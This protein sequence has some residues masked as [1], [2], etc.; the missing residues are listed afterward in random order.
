MIHVCYGLHDRDGRYSKFTGTSMLSI[1]ENTSAPSHSITVHILHDSTLSQSNH[2]KFVEI[3]EKYKQNVEFF[4]VEIFCMDKIQFVL[5]KLKQY[6]QSRFS[7]G[8]FY[9][10]M[11]NQKSFHEKISKMI[12]LDSDTIV[13]LDIQEL[14]DYPM[15]EYAVASV[16]ELWATRSYMVRNK[17]LL[18]S[19]K[20][21]VEDYFCSGVLV[22]NFDKLE[23]DFFYKG[24]NWLAENLQCECPDQDIL[25]YFFST[26]YCKLPEKF[27]LFVGIAKQQDKNIVYKNIY[28]YSGLS[29]GLDMKNAHDKLFFDCFMKT[30]WFDIDF[31][32]HIS[33]IMKQIYNEQK[34]FAV[35]I[36]AAIS[37]KKRAFF[38]MPNDIETV[39]KI[40]QISDEEEI[41]VATSNESIDNLIESMKNSGGKK[42]YFIVISTPGFDSLLTNAGFK[43]GKDFI[44]AMVMLPN[45]YGLQ[46]PTQAI[47]KFL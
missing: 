14:W 5:Q 36:S 30:S 3:A 26:N 7:I 38:V 11:V 35:Q 32:E 29:L 34:N 27:D 46:M 4:N 13:N 42:I 40:F 25:N 16:P 9:R 47:I 10:L 17:Y 45:N 33:Q 20:V 37:G 24:V 39:K 12:Y 31:I 2:D 18:N 41:I 43:A 23:E 8:A 1:F 19:G 28:H 44:N 15:E 6:V 21:K 22:L